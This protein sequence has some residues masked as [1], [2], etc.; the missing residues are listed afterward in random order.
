MEA[1]RLA[2][3]STTADEEGDEMDVEEEVE[4]GIPKLKPRKVT[5][6]KFARRQGMC[7]SKWC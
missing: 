7:V 2:G 3:K 4:E 6:G 1:R 5:K